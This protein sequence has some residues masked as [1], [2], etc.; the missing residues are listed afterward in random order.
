MFMLKNLNGCLYFS[1]WKVSNM[2]ENSENGINSPHLEAIKE[3]NGKLDFLKLKAFVPWKTYKD[4]EEATQRWKRIFA[5][6]IYDKGLASRIHVL[7]F[8]KTKNQYCKM[9]KEFQ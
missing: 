7:Q 3:K 1:W 9:G 4:S 5:N 6:H 2:Y 8:N